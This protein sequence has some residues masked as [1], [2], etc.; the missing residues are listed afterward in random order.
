VGSHPGVREIAVWTRSK[1]PPTCRRHT[2][3]RPLQA[4]T[5]DRVTQAPSVQLQGREPVRSPK[6]EAPVGSRRLEG[7]DAPA[8]RRL[9]AGVGPARALASRRFGR[10]CKQGKAA[11]RSGTALRSRVSPRTGWSLSKIAAAEIVA[12]TTQRLRIEASTP[13]PE[14]SR[15]WVR[16]PSMEATERPNLGGRPR[17]CALRS[18]GGEKRD[19]RPAL[20]PPPASP[21]LHGTYPRID[22]LGAPG[23]AS[24]RSS[25]P[26]DSWAG[27]RVPRP[28]GSPAT[29]SR[30]W[31]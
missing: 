25:A 14:Q 1:K 17:A 19:K 22:D 31:L 13:R 5:S 28:S 23:P 24:S 20:T 30:D 15:V 29:Y 12:A 7:R 4:P 16:G 21:L 18:D 3:D 10:S 9:A 11:F 26:P 27:R 8:A 6:Q 2:R